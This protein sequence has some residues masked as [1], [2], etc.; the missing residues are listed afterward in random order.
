MFRNRWVGLLVLLG[1]LLMVGSVCATPTVAGSLLAADGKVGSPSHVHVLQVASGSCFLLGILSLGGSISAAASRP[2]GVVMSAIL[3][4][5]LAVGVFAWANDY[6]GEEIVLGEPPVVR[7]APSVLWSRQSGDGVVVGNSKTE[8]C[9]FS[10]TATPSESPCWDGEIA[11]V[12]PSATAQFALQRQ[13]FIMEAAREANP[14]LLTDAKW[15]VEAWR[16][17]HQV[18][19]NFTRFSW[20]DDPTSQRLIAHLYLRDALHLAGMDF[21]EASFRSW[22][23]I[24]GRFL[25]RVDNY[26]RNT[27]HGMMQNEALLVLGHGT[28]SPDGQKWRTLAHNRAV[29]YFRDSFHADGVFGEHTTGYHWYGM[30]QL[31]WYLAFCREY[32]IEIPKDLLSMAERALRYARLILHDDGTLPRVADTGDEVRSTDLWPIDKLPELKELPRLQ[33]RLSSAP[34]EQGSWVFADSGHVLWR[35]DQ[36]MMH[37]KVGNYSRAH[38]HPDALT[39]TLEVDGVPTI[40]GPGYPSYDDG[41]SRRDAISTVYQNTV[42]VDGKDQEIGRGR[43]LWSAPS[44]SGNWHALLAESDLYPGVS[45]RRTMIWGPFAG[46]VM[47]VDTLSSEEPHRYRQNFN[48]VS[49]VPIRSTATEVAASAKGH[50]AFEVTAHRARFVTVIGDAPLPTDEEGVVWSGPRGVVEVDYEG[51]P[52]F[53]QTPIKMGEEGTAR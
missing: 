47:V 23:R 52:T 43:L 3:A 11:W 34:G 51:V 32:D 2:H 39:F 44:G 8:N 9:A 48:V 29:Q 37:F 26:N 30:E 14:T 6:F 46:A 1:A 18:W 17:D 35:T 4:L 42:S 21:N 33:R 28:T 36:I 15:F 40:Q 50:V 16:R 22:A 12:Q 38:I 53:I 5:G 25:E 41:A 31:L 45:H 7:V 27:N 13:V 10:F 19:P 20:N 49:P 24:H